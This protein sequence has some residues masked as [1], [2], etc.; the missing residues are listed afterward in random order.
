MSCQP[1]LSKSRKAQPV[2]RVSGR[3]FFPKAPV[4]C[5]KCIPA[6]AETSV[7]SM[8]PDGRGG[9]GLADGSGVWLATS[10]EAAPGMVGV[11]ACLQPEKRSN[12]TNSK[13]LI[14]GTAGG[15]GPRRGS[16]AGVLIPAAWFVQHSIS[17]VL[18][19]LLAKRSL[20]AGRP[21]PP[22]RRRAAP[23]GLSA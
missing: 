5:L 12:E 17:D 21:Q 8:G 11:A 2:P 9:V 10:G 19:G 16:P 22:L 23:D 15:R 20:R 6:C 7:N 1:S 18:G 14:T 4:L 3:Y 13:Q